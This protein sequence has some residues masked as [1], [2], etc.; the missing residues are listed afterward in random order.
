MAYVQV[1]KLTDAL[2]N[3]LMV[4]SFLNILGLF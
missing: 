4:R 1:Y 2:F 3:I